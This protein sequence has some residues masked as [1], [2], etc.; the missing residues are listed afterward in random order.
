MAERTLIGQVEGASEAVGVFVND[1]RAQLDAVEDQFEI[2]NVSWF[3]I[4]PVFLE[5]MNIT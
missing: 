1:A 4:V 2:S 5:P 3:R